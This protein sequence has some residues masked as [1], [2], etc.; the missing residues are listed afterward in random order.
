V[1][2]VPNVEC[3]ALPGLEEFLEAELR[4]RFGVRQGQRFEW[5]RPLADL[6]TLR[7]ANGAYLV[8]RFA[9]RRPTALLGDQNL[10]TLAVMA[11]G[12]QRLHP[13]GAFRSFRISAAGRKSSTFRRLA[14]GI[15]ETTGLPH[16]PEDGDLLV[17]VRQAPA[18]WE[19]LLRLSPRPLATRAWRVRNW[20]G[21]LNATVAAAMVELTEP[22]PGQRFANLLCGSGTLLV[23]RLL[24]APAA[25]A[26]GFDVDDEALDA[27]R[28]N[29]VAAGVAEAGRLERVD[30]T[31]LGSRAG[32][33]DALAADLP[34]GNL[35]GTHRDNAALYPAVLREAARV[36]TPGSPF[37]VVTH[38]LRLLDSALRS[39]ADDWRV[40]R[41]FRVLQGGV[42]P[43]VALLRRR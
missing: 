11:A 22:R 1:G 30:A 21:A 2:Q 19:V 43:R 38:E 4:R 6:L 15:Q 27:A 29:V 25:S 3:E 33:F 5:R 39:T 32:P 9:G 7:T 16:D 34:Y 42:R 8:G 37:A 28:A 14:A 41:A 18:G 13:P 35:V 24:R 23:E 10:R 36:A 31:A 12:A 40:E 17:R 20:P 26:V